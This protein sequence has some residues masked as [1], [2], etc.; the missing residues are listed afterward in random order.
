MKLILLIILSIFINSCVCDTQEFSEL[1]DIYGTKISLCSDWDSK[2]GLK[3]ISYI[4]STE[5]LPCVVRNVQIWRDLDEILF[6]KYNIPI[7]FVVAP[8]FYDS[9]KDAELL[10]FIE[11][12][13]PLYSDSNNVFRHKY[14]FLKNNVYRTFL[15]N[16]NNEIILVGSPI[17][18]DELFAIYKKRIK[19]YSW[20]RF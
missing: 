8:K 19:R 12:S 13:Y 9:N 20:L 5:C 4:D 16:D 1:N 2:S 17:L 14:L 6:S 7:T 18:S 3:L 15:V 10:C 11:N